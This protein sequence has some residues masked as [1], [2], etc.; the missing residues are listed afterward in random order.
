MSIIENN[1]LLIIQSQAKPSKVMLQIEGR[2]GGHKGAAIISRA[3]LVSEV[4]PEGIEALQSLYREWKGQMSSYTGA[5]IKRIEEEVESALA[6]VEEE[7]DSRGDCPICD[8]PLSECTCTLP[9]G[10]FEKGVNHESSQV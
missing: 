1:K 10:L 6:L 2:G 8:K 3:K 9:E 4:W 7:F 5:Y